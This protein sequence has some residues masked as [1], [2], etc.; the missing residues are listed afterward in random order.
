MQFKSYMIKG[1]F[2]IF[3]NIKACCC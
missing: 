1:K 2:L 3:S